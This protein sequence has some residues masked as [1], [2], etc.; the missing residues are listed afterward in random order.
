MS[1]VLKA[2]TYGAGTLVNENKLCEK[3]IANFINYVWENTLGRMILNPYVVNGRISSISDFVNSQFNK[4]IE[5]GGL[6]NT[7]INES[8]YDTFIRWAVQFRNDTDYYTAKYLISEFGDISRFTQ[9]NEIAQIE[10]D[11]I[12]DIVIETRN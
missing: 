8:I 7:D 2:F 5:T 9:P 1:S 11:P 10:V 12:G 6:V 3:N 4:S